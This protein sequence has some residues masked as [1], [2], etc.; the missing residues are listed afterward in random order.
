MP[1]SPKSFLA[2]ALAACLVS[3]C[4]DNSKDATN[5][6]GS[7]PLTSTRVMG[8]QLTDLVVSR[9]RAWFGN[10]AGIVELDVSDPANA[11]ERAVMTA[12]WACT[13]PGALAR[14][15]PGRP[16]QSPAN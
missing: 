5:F 2:I 6:P 3:A 16:C 8:G 7:S 1:S 9:H 12:C 15:S 11:Q 10:P 13:E 14:D 4:S